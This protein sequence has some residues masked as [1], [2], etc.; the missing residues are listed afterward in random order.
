M[1]DYSRISPEAWEKLG[2]V[3]TATL[4]TELLKKGLRNTFLQGPRPL[5]KGRRMVGYAFTLRY[6]PMREDLDLSGDWDN[7]RNVQRIAVEAV[8]EGEVLCIDARGNTR[9]ATLGHILATRIMR[10]GAAGIVSDGCLRDYPDIQ[11]LDLPVY[12]AGANALQS[13]MQ[14]HPADIG[15]PIACGGV[16]VFPGDVLVGDDEGVICIPNHM[17]EEIAHRAHDREIQESFIWEKVNAGASIKHVYP[18]DAETLAEFAAWQQKR[19]RLGGHE[20]APQ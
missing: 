5:G 9:A 19:A 10:R 16:A 13:S 4:S 17:A 20:C 15:V 3:S 11:Q 2:R 6:I 7:T 14:H 12:A 18:P 8:G 1:A